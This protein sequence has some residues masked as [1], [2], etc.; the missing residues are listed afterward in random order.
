MPTKPK[1]GTSLE[2]KVTRSVKC[3]LNNDS[4]EDETNEFTQEVDYEERP[5]SKFRLDI[6]GSAT[7]ARY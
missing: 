1:R 7:T 3:S 4:K 6:T 2:V 5:V